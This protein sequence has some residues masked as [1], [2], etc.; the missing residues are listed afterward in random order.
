MIHNTGMAG[1]VSNMTF[2]ER[3][4]GRRNVEQETTRI[5]PS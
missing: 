5:S 3:F 4:E 1:N 2:Y